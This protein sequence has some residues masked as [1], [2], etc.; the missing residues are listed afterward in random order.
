MHIFY[1]LSDNSN[2][3]LL[4]WKE[5]TKLKHFKQLTG[6]SKFSQTA[7]K[8]TTGHDGLAMMKQTPQYKY[9]Y[10]QGL[11]LRDMMV[12]QWWNKHLKIQIYEDS[13]YFQM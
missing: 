3:L 2:I 5:R 10:I 9:M 13:H 6:I 8:K 12:L 7:V 1:L 4:V 11:S